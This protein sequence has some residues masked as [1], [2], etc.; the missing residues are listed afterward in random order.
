MTIRSFYPVAQVRDPGEAAAFFTRY[1]GFETTFTA[2][3]Y[4]SLRNDAHEL[5]F[6]DHGHQTIPEGFRQPTAGLLL[7]VEVDDAES[8]FERLVAAG[9]PIRLSLR[10]ETFGQRHFI[11]EGPEGVLVD[12]IEEIPPGADYADA[13]A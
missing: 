7:N 10:D 4:V 3:W 2:D 1:F 6:L 11:V 8:E 5:A 9:L 13:F 12:V